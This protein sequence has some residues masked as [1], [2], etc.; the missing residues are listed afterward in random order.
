M[1]NL[2][3]L[4]ANPPLTALWSIGKLSVLWSRKDERLKKKLEGDPT[5]GPDVLFPVRI[6]DF[7]FWGGEHERKVD[8]TKKKIAD[9]R[10]WETDPAIYKGLLERLIRDLRRVK[11]P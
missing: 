5:V 11:N 9:A 10:K 4:P 3:S 6:D 8:V 7:I 1:T 2:C